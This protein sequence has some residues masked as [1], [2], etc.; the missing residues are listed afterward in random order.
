M[1]YLYVLVKFFVFCFLYLL[2]LECTLRGNCN[3]VVMGLVRTYDFES[4][5]WAD[6]YERA[7]EYTQ[8]LSK[9]NI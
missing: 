1:Y 5:R 4:G 7:V 3:R 2:I 6:S 8:N 9:Y